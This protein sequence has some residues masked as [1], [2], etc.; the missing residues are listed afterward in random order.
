MLKVRSKQQ[1]LAYLRYTE[2][3]ADRPVLVVLNFSNVPAQ[4]QVTLPTRF[5]GLTQ[6]AQLQDLM[7]EKGEPVKV[8]A[9]GQS[10]S[11]TLPA[12]TSRILVVPGK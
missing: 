12:F 5:A 8:Q 3:P 10:L 1:V 11:L 9:T 6:A 2:N 7:L 4:A